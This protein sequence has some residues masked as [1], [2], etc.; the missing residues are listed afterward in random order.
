VHIEYFEN[1]SSSDGP[2]FS[3]DAGISLMG[4]YSRLENKKSVAIVMREEYQDGK[5]HY[6]L[7]ETRSQTANSFRGFN[8]RNNGN[9]FVSD[10]LDRQFPTLLMFSC[11]SIFPYYNTLFINTCAKVQK[12]N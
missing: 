1:G 6:P 11:N 5:I 9:R 2:A 10:Y 3:V 4:N 12:Y 8:L 7:F